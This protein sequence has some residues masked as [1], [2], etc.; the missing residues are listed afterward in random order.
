MRKDIKKINNRFVFALIL[1]GFF[2]SMFTMSN[3]IRDSHLNDDMK[4]VIVDSCVKIHIGDGAGS[5]VIVQNS[6][7]EIKVLTC[8]HLFMM[9]SSEECPLTTQPALPKLIEVSIYK[10]GKLFYPKLE[11]TIESYR[12]GIDLALLNVRIKD[13]SIKTAKLIPGNLILD[14]ERFDDVFCVG[15]PGHTTHTYVSNGIMASINHRSQYWSCNAPIAP[16][17]SGGG[18]F[19]II[20]KDLYLIGLNNQIGFNGG[21]IYECQMDFVSPIAIHHFMDNVCKD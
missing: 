17:Y 21:N 20:G 13:K 12:Q 1:V 14:I 4:N 7:E 16:G 8:S 9:P 19:T 15:F 3:R 11:A 2:L 6:G 5:G 10:N 18:V